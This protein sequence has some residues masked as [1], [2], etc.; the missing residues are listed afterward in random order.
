MLKSFFLQAEWAWFPEPLL[1]VKCSDP[2]H[3]G[4]F[5][6][7]LQFVVFW[8]SQFWTQDLMWSDKCWEGGETSPGSGPV[9]AAQEAALSLLPG[10]TG[11]MWSLLPTRIPRSLPAELLPSWPLFTLCCCKGFFP[12]WVGEFAF[13]LLEFHKVSVETFFNLSR[14]FWRAVTIGSPQFGTSNVLLKQ[15]QKHLFYIFSLDCSLN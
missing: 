12:S 4:S 5:L 13:V 2:C 15:Y 9:C 11:L 8:G 14:F 6:T 7:L 10:H 3:G 1:M